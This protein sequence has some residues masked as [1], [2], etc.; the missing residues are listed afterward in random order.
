VIEFPKAVTASNESVAAIASKLI[1][2][3]IRSQNLQGFRPACLGGERW[4]KHRTGARVLR[5]DSA[6]AGCRFSYHL[7]MGTQGCDNDLG[8]KERPQ[9]SC[10]YDNGVKARTSLFT[11]VTS[12]TTTPAL[13]NIKDRR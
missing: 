12:K 13:E 4:H 10:N 3:F 9:Y 1:I 6:K 5:C 7:L 2:F 11:I 8:K